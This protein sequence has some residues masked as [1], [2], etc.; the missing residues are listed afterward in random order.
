MKTIEAGKRIAL[1]NVLFATDFSPHSDLALPY[2]AAIAR[3]YGAK[4]YGAHVLSSEDYLFTAPDL[5]PAHME[6]EQRLQRE[7]KQ[8]IDEQ[9]EGF[10][11]ESLFGV[12]DVCSVISCFISEHDI[13]LLVV[14]THGRTGTRKLLVGSV[15][16]KI[17]RLALCPVLSI[18]PNVPNKSDDRIEFQRIL[19][20]TKFGKE[21]VAALPYAV[22]FAEEGQAE[23]ALLHVVEQPSAGIP[24]AMEVKSSLTRRLEELVPDEARSWCRVSY[25]IEFGHQFARAAERIVDVARERAADLIVLGLRPTHLAMSTVTHLTHTTAQHVVAHATCPVLT[26]RG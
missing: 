13:D 16:E 17:F 3:H 25:L 10:A 18:G 9:L 22:S 20:A 23:L 2:A 6:Q 19:F 14:G 11:H 26:V 7:V 5:W 12:G 1:K 24:D 8:H 4:L 21:S 15:A